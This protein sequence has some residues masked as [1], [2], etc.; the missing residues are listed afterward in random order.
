MKSSK[1]SCVRPALILILISQNFYNNL[2]LLKGSL[3]SRICRHINYKKYRKKNQ[4]NDLEK[5]CDLHHLISSPY[6][7]YLSG[8]NGN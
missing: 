3:F 7:I 4:S 1:I 8:T 6:L 5:L 2:F